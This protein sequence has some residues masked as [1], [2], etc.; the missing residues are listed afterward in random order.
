M[1]GT[2]RVKVSG[3]LSGAINAGLDWTGSM[4]HAHLAKLLFTR[5]GTC[6]ESPSFGH[7]PSEPCARWLQ[8]R[9]ELN[10]T[11]SAQ[12]MRFAGDVGGKGRTGASVET[13]WGMVFV[14]GPAFAPRICLSCERVLTQ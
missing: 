12:G 8:D 7:V 5:D 6:A 1:S 3:A 14:L 4:L 10:A 2:V 9:W 13:S 11:H